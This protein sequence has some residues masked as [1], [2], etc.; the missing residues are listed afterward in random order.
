MKKLLLIILF[1]SF[2]FSS[3]V[4]HKGQTYYYYLLKKPLGYDGATFAKKYTDEQWKKLFNDNAKGL[5]EFLLSQNPD[6]G[7]FLQSEKFNKVSPHLEA[8][9][10]QYASNR[11]NTPQ[12]IE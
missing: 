1:S 7:K 5:K 8:F 10:L 4:I 11:K 12:C 9:V 2:L 6:L 3:G